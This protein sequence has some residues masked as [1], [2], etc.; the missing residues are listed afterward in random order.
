M[1]ARVELE[2][3]G[4]KLVLRTEEELDRVQAAAELV[5]ERVAAVQAAGTT[6][7][8]DRLLI[9]V[10]LDLAGE[11]LDLREARRADDAD[12]LAAL[13]ALVL[14]AEGLANAPLR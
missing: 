14:Q 8:T 11:I 1:S 13:D 10:A 3:L 4:R 12:L 5:R 9:L 6:A 7:G 2:I